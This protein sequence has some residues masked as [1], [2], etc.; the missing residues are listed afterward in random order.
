MKIHCFALSIIASSFVSSP[1][2]AVV[3]GYPTEEDDNTI[4]GI[5]VTTS[6]VTSTYEQPEL[7]LMEGTFTTEW[8]ETEKQNI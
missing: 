8:F 6:T 7:S 3:N 5:S 1:I 2:L 4:D